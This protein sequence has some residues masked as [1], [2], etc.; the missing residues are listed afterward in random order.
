MVSVSSIPVRELGNLHAQNNENKMQR[1]CVN[2]A[3]NVLQTNKSYK[4]F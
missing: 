3:H 4:I 2:K 1:C